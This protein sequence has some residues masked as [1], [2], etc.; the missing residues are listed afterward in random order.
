VNGTTPFGAV[1][2]ALWIGAPDSAATT[3]VYEFSKSVTCSQLQTAGWDT[4]I[5]NDTQVLELKM[6]GTTA[7]KTFTVTTSVTPAPGEASVSHTFSSTTSVPTEVSASNGTVTLDSRIA[8][9]LATGTFSIHF[10]ANAMSGSF[11]ATFCPG[12]KEP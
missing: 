12:G 11:D 6:F 3:V 4:R 1:V 7:P 9:T 5:T 2:T 8:S 10:G